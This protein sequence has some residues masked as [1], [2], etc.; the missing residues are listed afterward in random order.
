MHGLTG[1]NMLLI[2]K[3]HAAC[4]PPRIW[5]VDLL[6]VASLLARLGAPLHPP[7]LRPVLSER[8][9]ESVSAEQCVHMAHLPAVR[10]WLC[11]TAGCCCGIRRDC[12]RTPYGRYARGPLVASRSGQH[13]DDVGRDVLPQFVPHTRYTVP[14]AGRRVNLGD[15]SSIGARTG[16]HSGVSRRGSGSCCLMCGIVGVAPAATERAHHLER[17]VS[18]MGGTLRHRGPDESGHWTDPQGR[19]ALAHT[20]LAILDLSPAGAQPM[21]STSGRYV[22]AYNGNFTI[23]THSDEC[24]RQTASCS[25]AAPTRKWRWPRSRAGAWSLHFS[26]STG[27]SRSLSGILRRRAY[28][29]PRPPGREAA[30]LRSCGWKPGFRVGAEGPEEAPS[31]LD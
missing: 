13:R 9:T 27:C 26:G 22:L 2:L 31:V 17:L 6:G 20:R 4:A 5:H 23:T 14:R 28:A 29:R 12:R 19:L 8:G 7:L 10:L 11:R 21:I 15:G 25:E 30:V 3:T 18:H 16:C 24:S 1:L